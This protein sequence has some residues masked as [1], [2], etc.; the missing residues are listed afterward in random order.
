MVRLRHPVAL[1]MICA[2]VL[3]GVLGSFSAPEP[4]GLDTS[5][6]EFS[7]LRAE[8]ILSGLL[9]GVAAP[10]SN[11]RRVFSERR[12]CTEENSK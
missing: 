7:T 8:V 6:V 4:A 1:L 9:Q 10:P 11:F 2:L 5:D 3:T 12:G